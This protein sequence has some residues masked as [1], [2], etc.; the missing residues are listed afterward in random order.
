MQAELDIFSGRPNPRWNLTAAQAAELQEVVDALPMTTAAAPENANLG[1]RGFIVSDAADT[2][3]RIVA[4]DGYVV[5]TQGDRRETR[6]DDSRTTERWLLQSGGSAIES[7][8]RQR[9]PIR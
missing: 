1:Y 7:S 3:W 8:V 5:V 9:V 6:K 2:S 4:Y